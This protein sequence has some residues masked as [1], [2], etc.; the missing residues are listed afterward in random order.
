MFFNAHL[1]AA[2][3][4]LNRYDGGLPLSAYLKEY[5]RQHK[6]AGSRDRKTISAVCYAFSRMGKLLPDLETREKM[7]AGCL[8]SFPGKELVESVRPEWKEILYRP[9]EDRIAFL[10]SLYPGLDMESLFPFPDEISPGM[11]RDAFIRSHFIQPDLF[12][13]LRPG[14]E[15]EGRQSLEQAGI[16][17]S[18][19]G[20]HALRI[21]NRTNLELA[22]KDYRYLVVQDL[23]S[24]RTGGFFPAFRGN[25][26][27]WDCCAGSGGKSILA[28]D[29]YPQAK[30]TVSDT[31][32]TILHRLSERFRLSGIAGYHSF[33]HDLAASPVSR[34]QHAGAISAAGFDLI[35]ADVPCSGS[36]T[37]GRTPERM[38]FFR[39]EEIGEYAALQKK[40]VQHA[41]PLLRPGGYLLYMTCS[42]YH[43]ENGAVADAMENS[44]G[45]QRISAD[46]IRGYEERADTMFAALFTL[47]A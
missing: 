42:V 32:A 25:V 40:I 45:L 21:R 18:A 46:L 28:R 30:L 14:Y 20:D 19:A 47:P 23:S 16:A 1:Q 35:V 22:G 15:D 41:I 31:R 13:R 26:S 9:L 3:Q 36:G 7:L 10:Q 12:V 39:Q 4:I 29:L 34:A 33:R 5:F 17:C 24:Q 43:R 8:L 11:D 38:S 6:K 2:A 37:W 44:F 27:I